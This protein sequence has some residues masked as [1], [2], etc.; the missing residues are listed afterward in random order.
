MR[1]ATRSATATAAATASAPG[2]TEQR[3]FEVNRFA[4]SPARTL[5]RDAA[6]AEPDRFTALDAIIDGATGAVRDFPLRA[7]EDELTYDALVVSVDD[8]GAVLRQPAEQ[9]ALFLFDVVERAAPLGVLDV[10]E[11]EHADIGRRD[12]GELANFAALIGPD[13]DDGDAVFAREPEEHHRDADAVVQIARDGVHGAGR[14]GLERRGDR[15]RRRG[16]PGRAGDRDDGAPPPFAMEPSERA[17][18]ATNVSSTSTTG[19]LASTGAPRRTSSARAPAR[20]G[21]ETKRWPS[22]CSPD[23]ATNSFPVASPRESVVTPSTARSASRRACGAARRTQNF[24][25][26]EAAPRSTESGVAI[27][28]RLSGARP[29]AAA[30]F[31]AIVE[32]HACSRR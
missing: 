26:R 5:D 28:G 29:S 10:D 9:I 6:A 31:D 3:R 22:K 11:R 27:S 19:T 24:R 23:S 21:V 2:K 20:D 32:A 4:A 16:F 13:L 14:D 1:A 12:R 18:R 17:E 7:R 30:R 8:G 15:A 25:E